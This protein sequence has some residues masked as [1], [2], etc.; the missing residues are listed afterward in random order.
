MGIDHRRSY[1]GMTQQ[2]LNGA[3]VV[4]GLEEMGGKTV[5][6]GMRPDALGELGSPYRHFNRFLDARIMQVI[7]PEFLGARDRRK[8]FLRKEP[9]PDVFL[10]RAG[11][12]LFEGV[13]EKDARITRGEVL[14]VEF[15]DDLKL[16]LQ[17]RHECLRY[18][19]GSVL[20]ALAV[21]GENA[22][23]EVEMLNPQFDALEEAQPAAV[24][25]LDHDIKGIFEM[26]G[27]R[28]YF[29]PGK[30]H[31]D[32]LRFFGAG[33]IPL[34]SEILF[35][36]MPEKEEQGIEGLI[37]SGGGDLTLHGQ[38]GEVLFYIGRGKFAGL[39]VAQEALKL[40]PPIRIGLER[41]AGIVSDFAAC[42]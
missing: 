7:A 27:D 8:R 23:L 17:L 3:D 41:F 35:E 34:V 40:S 5:P 42:R 9:L 31:R 37:L 29:R 26:L 39:L 4:I 36:D 15:A 22:V 10:G 1:V 25:Q 18:R 11:I 6:K 28:V 24:Q 14:V 12:F 19:H 38:E 21:D 32:I 16:L 30:N 33:H 20:V 13:V 2:S